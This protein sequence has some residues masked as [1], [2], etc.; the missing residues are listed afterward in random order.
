MTWFPNDEMLDNISHALGRPETPEAIDTAY[1]NYYCCG[2][3]GPDSHRFAASPYWDW[4]HTINQDPMLVW[5]VTDRGKEFL[6]GA[7]MGMDI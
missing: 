3:D 5:H 4:S 6:R 2:F 1:R 7:L